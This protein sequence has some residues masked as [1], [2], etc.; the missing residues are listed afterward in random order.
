[1][2]ERLR[3]YSSML[4][5]HLRQHRQ[6]AFVSGPR[7]VG[8]TTACRSLADA[9]LNW[10]NSDDRLLMLRGPAAVAESL[11]FDSLRTSPPVAVLDEMHKYTKWK[12]LLK[13][14]FKSHKSRP[15]TR[16]RPCS[17]SPYEAADCFTTERPL[18]V[19]AKTL[20]SQL[21]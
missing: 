8:K 17:S 4:A 14:C 15:P 13:G 3:L 16:S 11:G 7:Q 1:M 20:L 10:D 5:E 2:S 12:S 18:V 6:M 9:Y 19:P 21:L